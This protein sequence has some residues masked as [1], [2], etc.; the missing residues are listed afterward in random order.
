MDPVRNPFAPGAG[1]PPPELSGRDD[2]LDQ[3]RITLARIQQ[4][5]SQK[6]LLMVGLRGVGKTVLLNRIKQVAEKDGYIAE[7]VEVPE[8][9]D[10]S[11]LLIPV[12]RKIFL[13]LDDFS[14]ASIQVK[15]AFRILKSFMQSV[16]FSYKSHQP[17]PFV[18]ILR[19][20]SM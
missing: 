6:S 8:K 7:L 9:K 10:I 11:S 4:G 20:E 13:R 5:R 12:L 16:K 18:N 19:K 2:I 1:S 15:R 3:A 14:K 17:Y